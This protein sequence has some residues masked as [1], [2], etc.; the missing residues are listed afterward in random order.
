MVRM[1]RGQGEVGNMQT[2]SGLKSRYW[3]HGLREPGW[4]SL[5]LD[6]PTT[7]WLGIR[8]PIA[9]IK[10]TRRVLV[11]INVNPGCVDR[12]WAEAIL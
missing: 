11:G 10:G 5:F 9:P 2:L 7:R 3:A 6:P 4:L 1:P 8:G 12:Y